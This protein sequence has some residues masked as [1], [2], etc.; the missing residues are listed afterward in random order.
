MDNLLAKAI[1]TG[2]LDGQCYFDGQGNQGEIA[3]LFVLIIKTF[4]ANKDNKISYQCNI[5][6]RDSMPIECSKCQIILVQMMP[7][8]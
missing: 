3:L 8:Y 5:I 1:T 2:K 6:S 7:I 4:L